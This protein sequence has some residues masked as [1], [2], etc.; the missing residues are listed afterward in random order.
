MKRFNKSSIALA[1][2]LSLPFVSVYA[3]LPLTDEESSNLIPMKE[4][5][6]TGNYLQAQ[7]AEDDISK[8]ADEAGAKYYHIKAL[9]AAET[10]NSADSAIVYADI[11]QSNAPIAL[12]KEE[13]TYNGIVAYERNKALYY[14]PFEVVKF[15]GSFNNTSEITTEASKIAADKD[16]YAFYISSIEPSNLKNQSQDVE[17]ALYKKDAPV[18][19]YIVTKAIEGEDAYEI[20]SDAF[21]TMKPYTTIVF[22][23]V[24]NNTTEISAAAQKHAIANGAQFYYVKEVSTNP[25]N[26]AQTV[27]VNL[28]K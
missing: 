12:N 17:V 11:Y 14:L 22:H 5:S 24:F 2:L 21:K 19:D 4:I 25:A 23:G 13:T 18:R 10:S 6:V 1:V 20:S 27:Y 3:A 9:E 15:K 16:A 8:A 7:N 26:T 28:Y